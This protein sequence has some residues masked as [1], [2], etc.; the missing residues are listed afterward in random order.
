MLAIALAGEQREGMCTAA[1][2][3][4]GRR[5]SRGDR[6]GKDNFSCI[7]LGVRAMRSSGGA[8]PRQE[9]LCAG[10][11]PRH[12]LLQYEL[13]S[14]QYANED[15]ESQFQPRCVSFS[16]GLFLELF[17][18]SRDRSIAQGTSAR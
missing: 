5:E 15:A 4:L 11:H 7:G 12:P 9:D 18:S 2:W 16:C 17:P 10:A 1:G 8:A 3:F 13:L 6:F 14:M